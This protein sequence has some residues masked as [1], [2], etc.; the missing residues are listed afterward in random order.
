[1]I[2]DHLQ[3][4]FGNLLFVIGIWRFVI[5]KLQFAMPSALFNPP[6]LPALTFYFQVY[7]LS[8]KD[9]DGD[10]YGDLAGLVWT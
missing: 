4:N 2:N 8:L 6:L 5:G 9:S 3:L 10:G 1:M 7:P